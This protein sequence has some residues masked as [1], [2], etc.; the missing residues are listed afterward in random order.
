MRFTL[1]SMSSIA[2]LSSLSVAYGADN[3]VAPE[4]DAAQYV[5]VCD[6]YGAGYFYIPGTETCL[7]VHGYVRYLM[8]GGDD[9]YGRGF[10][11]KDGAPYLQRSTKR[12]TWDIS[13]R[14]TLRA[15]TASETELGT[16]KTYAE[17]RF[18][19]SNGAD[20]S[21]TGSLRVA[22]VDLGGLRVGLDYSV[23]TSFVGYLGDV[24]N[25][26]V[27][28]AGG[29]RTAAISYTYTGK[30]GWSAVLALEQG[31]NIDTDHDYGY[32]GTISDYAPHVVGGVKYSK[33]W[34][35]IIAVAAYDARNEEW[36]G[37]LRGNLNITDKLSLWA[38]G[39]YKSNKDSYMDVKGEDGQVAGQVR[40]INSF[41]GQWGGDWA[42]WGGGA[43]KLSNKTVFNAELSYDG[44]NTFYTTAN[45]AYEMVPG[46]TV[47]PEISYVRWRDKKS[48]LN[49]TDAWQGLIMLQRTF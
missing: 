41:Y 40:A 30:D 25:D 12:D 3:I 35:A 39:A 1:L 22:Y 21:S 26:D 38:M 47:T 20:S 46:F 48:V 5:R 19:W 2:T 49:G 17:T 43:Y 36:A 34:G 37:K 16:L 31:N 14:F 18:Q 15:S 29:A 10:T 8:Q 24:F 27:I 9:V 6:A 33:D 11:D 44:V 45:V 4:P 13:T 28:P 23:F 32:D 7:R 42:V